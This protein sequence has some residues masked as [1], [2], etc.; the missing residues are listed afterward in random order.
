MDLIL[1]IL[2]Q[3]DWE[4]AAGPEMIGYTWVAMIMAIA[5]VMVVYTFLYDMIAVTLYQIALDTGVPE[6][7]LDQIIM[8]LVYFPAAF[9]FG[10][11]IWAVVNSIRQEADTWRI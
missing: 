1:R 2:K 3:I 8:Y 5:Y 7:I 11:I 4:R 6:A 9:L 10:L